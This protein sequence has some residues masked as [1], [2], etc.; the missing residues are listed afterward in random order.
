MK[1]GIITITDGT[2]YGN[3]LQNYAL[4]KTLESLHENAEVVTMN[5][6]SLAGMN[7]FGRFKHSV[8]MFFTDRKKFDCEKRK[9]KVFKQYNEDYLKFSSEIVSNEMLSKAD[10]Y[11]LFVC[12]SDQIWNPFYVPNIELT[13]AYNAHKNAEKISYAA[14]MGV[15]S[16]PN[17][18]YDEF[19]RCINA[20]DYIA[21]RENAAAEYLSREIGRK[22]EVVVDPTLLL[23]RDDWEKFEVEPARCPKKYVLTY[24]LTR[25]NDEIVRGI[26][27]YAIENS[28]DIVNLNDSS[29]PDWY[30]IS[31]NEF[32]YMIHHSEFFFTDSFHGTVFSLIF[33]KDFFTFPRYGSNNDGK[34]KQGSR[35]KTLL[36]IAGKTER[37]IEKDSLPKISII[38][39]SEVDERIETERKKS[40]EYLRKATEKKT[41]FVELAEDEC[42]GCG[43]CAEVCPTEAIRMVEID[44]FYYSHISKELCINCGK[45]KRIC[46]QYNIDS[47]SL[48]NSIKH[49]AYALENANDD[50]RMKSSSGGVFFELAS[51]FIEKGGVVFSPCFDENFK[52]AHREISSSI[53]LSKALGSKYIQSEAWQSYPK[54][55]KYLEKGI[56]VLFTG[57]P[58]QITALKAYLGKEYEN[59]YTQD[60]VCHGVSS[61][62]YFDA[63][64]DYLK[65]K[66]NRK[67]INFY[68]RNKDNGWDPYSIKV[69]FEDGSEIVEIC[70]ENV[71]FSLFLRNYILRLSCYEN[72]VGRKEERKSDITLADFWGINKHDNTG[73]SMVITHSEKGEE[74]LASIRNKMRRFETVPFEEAIKSNSSYN[75]GI[76]KPLDKDFFDK[77]TKINFEYLSRKYVDVNIIKKINRKIQRIVK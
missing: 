3:K 28:F 25:P 19:C 55:K 15:E 57:T 64:R 40:L 39:Y 42:V 35:V 5:N 51:F 12:G 30:T 11:D 74:M 49:K 61:K 50:I 8:K 77:E 22:I 52:L 33:H 20:L 71:Y 67:I 4:L 9:Y 6:Y 7:R 10:D 54:V 45:C 17:D 18:R 13:T 53:D 46:P 44:G 31:P 62:K 24:F 69:I 56:K 48:K 72:C 47:A 26:Q 58:C 66:Y 32:L 23:Y 36:S 37:F 1:I 65:K 41:N 75:H 2:N 27:K 59:L 76:S 16:V 21:V 68:Y 43:A 29:Q 34:Q 60:L 14:S 70:R 63:Y 73:T 38:D